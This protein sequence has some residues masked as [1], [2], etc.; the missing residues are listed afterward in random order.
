MKR[1][2]KFVIALATASAAWLRGRNRT[3][4]A[5]CNIAEGV[6]EGAKITKLADVALTSRFLVVKVGSDIDHVAICTAS[7]IPLG[8]AT[9]EPTAADIASD[10]AG[11]REYFSR[12]NVN[13]FGGALQETQRGQAGSANGGVIAAGDFIT[14]DAAGQLKTKPAAG[15]GA[16][17]CVG[18]ALQATTAQGQVFEFTPMFWYQAS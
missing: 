17:Y 15:G 13:V 11:G 8:I 9:D 14:A 10:T 7:D 12:T 5:A 18:R 2:N 1:F 3:S 4:V 6:H 16:C